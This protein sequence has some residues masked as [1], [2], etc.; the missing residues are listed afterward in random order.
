[1]EF[2]YKKRHEYTE[3]MKMIYDYS[4]EGCSDNS[5]LIGNI[6]RQVLEAFSTFEY[7]KGIS[8]VSTDKS[9][10]NKLDDEYQSYFSNLMYRLILNGGSHK[11]EETRSGRLDFF[12]VISDEEKVRTAKDILCFIYLLNNINI[13]FC[14]E[15]N[16]ITDLVLKKSIFI[17]K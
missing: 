5:I 11:E 9:I 16:H 13:I 8:E 6:M 2:Q 10:I 15:Y 4:M 17:T 7:K 1:M 14:Y 3:M 12:T